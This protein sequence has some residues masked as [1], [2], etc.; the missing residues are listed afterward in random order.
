MKKPKSFVLIAF[1]MVLASIYY[2]ASSINVEITVYVEKSWYYIED[3]IKVYGILTVDGLPVENETVA[4]EVRDPTDSP[5]IVRALQTNSSGVYDTIFRF[6]SE[7]QHG[8]YTIHVS[9]S[10]S[11]VTAK[12]STSFELRES[13]LLILTVETSNQSYSVEETIDVHGLVT[14]GGQPIQSV[15]VAIEVQDP[16]N[17]PVVVR[18]LETN[19]DGSYSLTFQMSTEAIAGTYTV[20]ASLSHEGQTAIADTTFELQSLHLSAD[21]NGDGAVNIVDITLAAIAWGSYPGHPRWDP[22]CDLDGNGVINIID[23][24]L[25]ALEYNP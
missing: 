19:I 10:H 20:H 6:S 2:A 21:I 15:L 11:S 7:S 5:V 3:D 13:S 23:I 9:C 22:R 12:N 1:L 4:L 14:L 25:V 17:T 16:L 8:A 24:A 18:V